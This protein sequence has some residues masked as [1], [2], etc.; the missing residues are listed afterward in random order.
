M[1]AAGGLRLPPIL[2]LDYP[3]YYNDRRIRTKRKGLPPALH[4]QQAPC[5]FSE[6]AGYAMVAAATGVLAELI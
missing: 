4:R 1:W 6:D 5:A 3:D 2:L